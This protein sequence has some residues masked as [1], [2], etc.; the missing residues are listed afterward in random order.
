MKFYRKILIVVIFILFLY[1]FLRLFHKTGFLSEGFDIQEAKDEAT[2]KT[3]NLPKP[4]IQSIANINQQV[5]PIA[6]S[7]V[8]T[9]SPASAFNTSM[10]PFSSTPPSSI[11]STSV[12]LT[13]TLSSIRSTSSPTT[14]KLSS[15]MPTRSNGVK[16]NFY[17][18]P[19]NT[20][21]S[22]MLPKS[23]MPLTQYC[24][25][26]SYNTAI[27][28][29]YV[30]EEML[31]NVLAQ[32]CRFID[33]EVFYDKVTASPFVAYTTD[34]SYNT[35]NTKN[36][37]ILDT[38]L[39][40]SVRD[41]FTKAPNVLDP[42]LIQLRIKSNDINVYRSVAKSVKYALG[43]K[44]YTKQITEKTTLDDVMGKVILIVDKTLN[45]SWKQNSAC[46]SDP[47]C[48]DLSAF[49][50]IE[51]GSELMRIERYDDLAKQTTIPPH[52]MNDNMNTDVKLIRIVEPDLTTIT[53]NKVIKNP[54]FKDYVTKYGA[55]IVTYNYNNQDQGLNDYENFFSEIGFAFVPISSAIQYFKQ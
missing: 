17:S 32:G 33:F 43:E 5:T 46:I 36:K 8:S 48:Y 15:I 24:I 23:S 35:I 27:S 21:N 37:I 41:G 12:P 1:L 42:L 26:S 34:P 14:T 55:Q 53:N 13:T 40:R 25:K 11:T 28:G 22:W 47:N 6:G 18:P 29:D 3:K 38:I 19:E 51:S 20:N 44:L 30:S 39:S 4:K 52:I 10:R 31:S 2:V 50:N 16:E 49:C 54:A 7:V 45:L 9:L